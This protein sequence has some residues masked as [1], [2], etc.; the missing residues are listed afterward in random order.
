MPYIIEMKSLS[1]LPLIT[2]VY[3]FSNAPKY[4]TDDFD[5]PYFYEYMI[6]LIE[7]INQDVRILYADYDV[8]NGCGYSEECYELD[9]TKNKYINDAVSKLT[10]KECDKLICEI[11]LNNA[12]NLYDNCGYG[13]MSFSEIKEL[14]GIRRFMY[15]IIDACI[16][17]CDHLREIEESEYNKLYYT[18]SS[19]SNIIDDV[20]F[21][22]ELD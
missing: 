9:D 2:D 20:I 10:Y 8:R 5:A 22:D 13:D 19:V 7:L 12:F 4:L 3:E 14:S 1:T 6:E 16:D 21:R 17:K 11:G 15:C 18:D